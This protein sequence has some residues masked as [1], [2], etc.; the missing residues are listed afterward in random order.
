MLS[1]SRR[2]GY[3][4]VWKDREVW[5]VCVWQPHCAFTVSLFFPAELQTT[6]AITATQKTLL[7]LLSDATFPWHQTTYKQQR[8]CT[9]VHLISRF[10]C[11]ISWWCVSPRN[12][13]LCLQVYFQ[14]RNLL[15]CCCCSY[16]G[17]GVSLKQSWFCMQNQNNQEQT[18]KYKLLKILDRCLCRFRY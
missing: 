6:V 1:S 17:S 13:W 10:L 18:R 11:L 8:C 15:C 3:V 16:R 7:Q 5:A 12:N 2:L 9:W 4:C 14:I